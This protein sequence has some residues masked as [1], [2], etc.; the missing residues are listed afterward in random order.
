MHPDAAMPSEVTTDEELVA[1][2][3]RLRLQLAEARRESYHW[4]VH[5]QG[6][7]ES[8]SVIVARMMSQVFGR[9]APTG[10]RRRR[11]SGKLT[12]GLLWLRRRG[13]PVPTYGTRR[14][15]QYYAHA[16]PGPSQLRSRAAALAYLERH[17]LV[18]VVVVAAR[19]ELA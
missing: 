6:I 14:Y 11:W 17:P 13:Q 7:A 4:R 12:E 1:E 16:L 15:R 18:S 10:T 2:N 3:H 5:V 8:R 9:F 19:G